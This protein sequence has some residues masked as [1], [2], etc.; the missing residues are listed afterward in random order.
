MGLPVLARE[1]SKFRAERF[2]VVVLENHDD[3]GYAGPPLRKVVKDRAPSLL[4]APGW[5]FGHATRAFDAVYNPLSYPDVFYLLRRNG[6]IARVSSAPAN[7]L[8]AILRFARGGAG[9]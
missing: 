4:H 6:T 1:A 9:R 7:H 2:A 3:G 8:G 5:T